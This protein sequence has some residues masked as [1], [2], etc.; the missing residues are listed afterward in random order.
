M[1]LLLLLQTLLPG[2]EA[3]D[4]Y[5]L[6]Q[7]G[8]GWKCS[9][10]YLISGHSGGVLSGGLP[11]AAIGD[12]PDDLP[13]PDGEVLDPLESGI[14]G[15]GRWN[16]SFQDSRFQDSLSLS[17]I[18]LIQNTLDRSRYL[19]QLNRPLPW[20]SAANLGMFRDD[21]VSLN[22]ALFHRRGFQLRLGEWGRNSGHG[23]GFWSGYSTGP[24]YVRG[25]FSRLYED[26]RR[27]EVLGGL[28]TDM[29]PFDLEIGAGAAHVDTALEYRAAAGFKVPIGPFTAVAAGD[30]Q[31]D[32]NGYWGGVTWATGG[33][34]ISAAHSSPAGGSS[35]QSIALRHEKF[36][37]IGRF[38]HHP[39][40]SADVSAGAGF[41]RG[42]A[43]ACW[44][45]DQDSLQLNCHALIGGDWYRG[46][47]EAGPRF[48]GS[49]NSLGEWRGTV[50]AVAGFV[51][52]PFSFGVGYEDI[53]AGEEASWSFG[54]T[55]AFT[56]QPPGLPEGER[57]NGERN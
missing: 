24:A 26:D 21:T 20:A 32:E 56:D 55:W 34:A 48:R 49:M 28:R 53:T 11:L 52:L 41:L 14:W 7:T 43:A 40:V 37:L 23:W 36:T 19:F 30:R 45:F 9:A 54:I 39:A 17:R 22:S 13:W 47:F 57:G 8:H 15:G 42:S 1:I 31:N 5:T 6:L 51:L 29:G 33:V 25:G 10:D 38:S 18:G 16:T 3:T 27:P 50:D 12:I 4:W 46:R 44:S 35:F 2:G